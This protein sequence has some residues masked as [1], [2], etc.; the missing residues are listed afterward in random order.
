MIAL[1]ALAASPTVAEAQTRLPST[2]LAVRQPTSTSLS[3]LRFQEIASG[4]VLIRT[5]NCH[6][7]WTGSGSGFLVGSKV[8][9]TARHVVDH[10]GACS[11]KVRASGRW[12]QVKGWTWWTTGRNRGIAEDLATLRLAS[13]APGHIFAFRSALP[14]AGTNLAMVGH[15]L[16]NELSLTQGRVLLRRRE[17]G[18]PILYVRLLGA[19]GAS[20]SPFV[21][22]NGKV[23]GIL[24]FG[25]GSHDILGQKT[26]GV[27]AGLDL[28]AWWGTQARKDL[29]RAYRLG[30]IP[31]CGSTQSPSPPADPVIEPPTIDLAWIST[32]EAGDDEQYTVS[33]TIGRVYVQI[34]FDAP[35]NRRQYLVADLYDPSGGLVETVDGEMEKGWQGVFVKLALPPSAPPGVW[36]VSLAAEGIEFGE[37]KF[38]VAP[39]PAPTP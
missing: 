1:A 20:G 9:M 14:R 18:A 6:G 17:A 38:E 24:Q 7:T 16:G 36:R 26:S 12:I 23:A 21:D 30:G 3:P 32:D 37:V 34:T 10:R 33:P 35:L 25:L 4:V 5:F 11:I 13:A 28:A 15:P 19:E 2:V 31:N 22:N 39:S 27:V 29:C 8:V